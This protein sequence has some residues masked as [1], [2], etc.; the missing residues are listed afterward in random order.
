MDI[1]FSNCEYDLEALKDAQE[2]SKIK[3]DKRQETIDKKK[4]KKKKTK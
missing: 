4:S 2:K 1:I 3:K